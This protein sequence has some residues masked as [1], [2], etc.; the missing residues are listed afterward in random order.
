MP[1]TRRFLIAPSLGRLIRKEC[2]AG[3]VTEGHFPAHGKRY[4]HVRF[5]NGRSHLVLTTS[6]V[7]ETAEDWT[8]LPAAHAQ[9][10][11]DVC[12]GKVVFERSRLRLS[13]HEAWIDRFTTP[14]GLELASIQFA[15]QGEAV[16]FVPPAWFG[17]EVSQDQGYSNS[18]I[19]LA[20]LPPAAEAPVTDAALHALL[21]TIEGAAA[22]GTSRQPEHERKLASEQPEHERRI[23]GEQPEH[24]PET[25]GEQPA[26]EPAIAGGQD[27]TIEMLRRLAVVPKDRVI[28]PSPAE[29][30]SAEASD[31][32]PRRPTILGRFGRD[33]NQSGD[34]RL[35]QVIDSLSETLS[36]NGR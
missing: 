18:K 19:A 34:E 32:R 25:A 22:L 9:S 36:V 30:T 2:G 1:I 16:A 28:Q 14:G 17:D 23:A 10:L 33:Q 27:G 8:E 24:E 21:D 12:R 4:S 31:S 20:G 5:E 26:H 7:T 3:P 11:L 35:S 6:G 29:D 13:G 15:T